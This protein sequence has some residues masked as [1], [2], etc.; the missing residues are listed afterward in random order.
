M[1]RES[2]W[3][4]P[5]FAAAAWLLSA[6]YPAVAPA[7]DWPQ[8]RGPQ[9][10]GV[11]RETGILQA[12]PAG[13]LQPEWRAPVGVGFS[14]PV[15][16]G[17][18]VYVTDSELI[19]PRARERVHALDVANGKVVWS[20]AQDVNYPDWAFDP[21]NAR[22][23]TAT[24]IVQDGRLFTLGSLGHLNSFDAATG[25]V[26]WQH[27]LAAE[28]PEKE[29]QCSASPLVEG[30]RVVVVVG[31]RP[32]ATVIAFDRES[33]KEAWHAIDEPASH[34][35][36][37]VI[38]DRD[39]R[40]LIV[41]SQESVTSLEPRT[42]SVLW[43]QKLDTGSDYAVSSP[44]ARGELL[45]IGGCMLKLDPARAGAAVLWPASRA[46]ARRVFSN[47]STG[48]I[49]DGHVVSARST[50]ELV[51]VAASTGAEIWRTEGVTELRNGA[52]IH[53]TVHE[54]SAF[55]FNERGELIL[56]KLTPAAYVE[57][58]RTK[59]IEPTYPFGGRNCAWSPPAFAR[60]R[61]FV[62]SDRELVCVS[63]ESHS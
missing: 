54:N 52:S 3:S 37:L 50:G 21:K 47:T 18:R 48:A 40:Q 15:V 1:P 5:R 46:I 39:A 58:G 25:K 20:H 60:R 4:T 45:L 14:S 8:W 9:R 31:A 41:W 63:L 38:G 22:G 62:R 44:V 36:P 28:H 32:S 34:S 2:R 43:R 19:R 55:L 56:A 7:D 10:D 16:A 27:D 11:W 13:G 51:C 42:G 49:L 61:V 30:D 26:L 29:L 17:D 53:I 35:S 59:L 33:G 6:M 12:I 57:V 23:P 24:P